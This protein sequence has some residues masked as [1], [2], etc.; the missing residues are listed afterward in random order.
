M[1]EVVATPP[2]Q[3]VVPPAPVERKVASTQTETEAPA[4]MLSQ[5]S[6]LSL[7]LSQAPVGISGHNSSDPNLASPEVHPASPRVE[8]PVVTVEDPITTDPVVD[9]HQSSRRPQSSFQERVLATALP[10]SHLPS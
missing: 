9:T 3:P 2:P 4:K 6:N 8:P 10:Q 1:V 5:D 7:S